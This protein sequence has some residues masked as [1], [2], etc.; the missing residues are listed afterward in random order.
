MSDPVRKVKV[1]LTEDQPIGEAVRGSLQTFLSGLPVPQKVELA[2]RGNREV[3]TL[4][5]RDPS[6]LVARAVMASP[7]LANAD[8]LAYASS[9]LTNEEILRIIGESPE[10]TR[11]PR[12]KLLLVSNPRTPAPVSLRFLGPLPYSELVLLSRN[13]GVSPLIRSEARKRAMRTRR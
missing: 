4:L 5:S 1:S 8:V 6:S 10:W 13:R 2:T 3:R 11:H 9:S 7:R 12:V